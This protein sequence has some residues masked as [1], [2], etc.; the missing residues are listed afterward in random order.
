[1]TR[2]NTAER[3][4]LT[5]NFVKN[6][7]PD[8]TR[9]LEYKDDDK[10]AFGLRLRVNKG[11]TKTYYIQGRIKGED[12]PR[13]F[14]IGN[15]DH[16]GIHKA[17]ELAQEY[18]GY[19]ADGK[20]PVKTKTAEDTRHSV[21]L[22]QAFDTYLKVRGVKPE[23]PNGLEP[24]TVNDYTNIFRRYLSHWSGTRL[25]DITGEMVS[26]HHAA[27]VDSGKTRVPDKM[28]GLLR[29]I[30]NFASGYYLEDT[31]EKRPLYSYNPVSVLD[32]GQQWIVKGGQSRV[33]G[34]AIR[35][36]HLPA[37]WEAIN[38]IQNYQSKRHN[39][40]SPLAEPAHYYFK[41]MLFT[42]IRPSAAAETE[43]HQINLEEGHISYVD[44]DAEKV[45]GST[46]I[47]ELPL[48]DYVLHM[49]KEMHAKKKKSQRY[50]FPNAGGTGPI[51]SGLNEWAKKISAAAEGI[52]GA[53]Y[54]AHDYRSTFGTVADSIGLNEWTIKRLMNHS[55]LG[56]K[57]VT[58]GYI[59]SEGETLRKHTQAVT[60]EILRIVGEAPAVAGEL[61]GF[62]DDLVKAAM[63]E[64]EGTAGTVKSILERWA[65][66]GYLADSMSDTVTVE[67]LKK[68]AAMDLA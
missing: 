28:A 9:N 54:T 51:A 15:A 1:M 14:T 2:K 43:W 24:E 45:K 62:D 60:N 6:L 61:E 55:S 17:R 11:G 42:G 29:L 23:K 52:D 50:L 40:N 30:F 41:F 10:A 44:E 53:V 34:N 32:V 38:N 64:V 25:I 57:D 13:R 58:S 39:K 18:H 37:M 35:R 27:M 46:P 66:L 12:A 47:F 63:E 16:I 33:K 4:V 5:T 36:K 65:R 56:S 20:D 59:R 19:M 22:R 67:R 48:S 49:L 7:N 26:E 21:T 3:V 8:P 31:P 68:M